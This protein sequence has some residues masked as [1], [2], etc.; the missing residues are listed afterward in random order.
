MPVLSLR[1]TVYGAYSEMWTLE[2][3]EVYALQNLTS[4]SAQAR[5][6]TP[7]MVETKVNYLPCIGTE[8]ALRL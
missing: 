2:V 6:T 7:D 1:L 8:V 5:D 4:I 3:Q